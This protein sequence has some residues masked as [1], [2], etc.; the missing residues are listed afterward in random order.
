MPVRSVEEE[1]R[2]AL[3]RLILTDTSPRFGANCK[4]AIRISVGHVE[5]GKDYKLGQV[6]RFS[7]QPRLL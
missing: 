5:L 6:F 4:V 1:E 3:A 2:R 7:V